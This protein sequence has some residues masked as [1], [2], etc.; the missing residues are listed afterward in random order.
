M[1]NSYDSTG[2]SARSFAM[3]Y[4]GAAMPGSIEG[5]YYN[6]ASLGFINTEKINDT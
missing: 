5:V 4:T 6:S 2:L 1:P 3:G